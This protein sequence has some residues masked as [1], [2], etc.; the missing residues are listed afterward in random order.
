MMDEFNDY[1]HNH[2][3]M[4]KS[5]VV[6]QFSENT[7]FEDKKI[8][9]SLLTC[10]VLAQAAQHMYGEMFRRGV[11]YIQ[12]KALHGVVTIMPKEEDP[13]IEA[14]KRATYEFACLYPTAKGVD[15]TSSAEV[16]GMIDVLCK[17]IIKFLKEKENEGKNHGSN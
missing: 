16:M 6:R 11:K 15:L 9:G 8:L 1:I 3:V 12:C 13:F 14:I 2:I 4:L 5:T 17:K 7:P 10:N